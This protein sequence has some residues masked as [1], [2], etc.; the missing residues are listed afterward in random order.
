MTIHDERLGRRH[1]LATAAP[2][3]AGV[4]GA[5]RTSDRTQ[6]ADRA[7]GAGM[8]TQAV[9][10]KTLE[11][12]RA[13]Y[14]QE[15][16]DVVVPFWMRHGVDREHGGFLCGLDYDGSLVHTEKFHWFQGRG[17]WVFSYLYNHLQQDPQYLDIA[18]GTRDFMLR[19]ARQPNGRWAE[20]FSRDGRILQPFR[21]DIGGQLFLA[22]GLQEYAW[23]ARDDE[24]RELAFNLLKSAF[25]ERSRREPPPDQDPR[26]RQGFSMVCVQTATQM[27]RRWNDPEI[28]EIAEASVDAVIRHHYNPDIGLNTEHLAHDF[29]RPPAEATICVLGHSIETLWMILDEARRRKDQR[30]EA[31]CVERIRRH[32]DA[33]WDHVYGGLTHAVNVDHPTYAWPPERP[34]GTS[35][36]FHFTGEFKYMKTTWSL[37]EV[38]IA[39]MR[40]LDAND[41]AWA[42]RYFS[43]AQAALDTWH[44]RRSH[45]QPAGYL[46]FSDRR[47]TPQPHVTRQ[48]NYHHLRA[49][50]L[51]LQSIDRMTRRAVSA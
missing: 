13:S 29:S 41:E 31:T 30:L 44:S 35:L 43:L 34:A 9:A 21:G 36:E 3:A 7:A 20:R 40:V 5:V 8:T 12:L 33:G 38:L 45:G 46:L 27:L 11:Q 26:R 51:C 49:L 19:H 22:E 16:F 10:G 6:A 15:L 42:T 37:D 39:M 24:A 4:L 1:F 18:R 14:R 48:D 17:M 32:L 25:R 50:M 2:L 47:H 28:A 23:A